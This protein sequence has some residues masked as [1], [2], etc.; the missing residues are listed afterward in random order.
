MKSTSDAEVVRARENH[1]WSKRC[2]ATERF[3]HRATETTA[4]QVDPVSAPRVQPE[5]DK[6]MNLEETEIPAPERSATI[7]R[8]HDGTSFLML[9]WLAAVV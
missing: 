1:R 6:E 3:E 4:S 8:F 7:R 2:L 5:S 9:D